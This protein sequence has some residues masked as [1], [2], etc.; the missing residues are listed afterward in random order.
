MT[1]FVGEARPEASDEAIV[2]R[3]VAAVMEHKL[4]PGAKLAENALCEAFG[5]NRTQIR[6][7]LVVLGERGVVTLHPN[8]GAFVWRPSAEEA[9]E[10]FSAR[11]VVET[12][13]VRGAAEGVGAEGVGR[14]RE[15]VAA[16]EAAVHRADEREAIRLSGQFHIAIAEIA[17]NMVLTR[18]LEDLVARTSLIIAFYGARTQACADCDHDEIIA[19][20][21]ARDAERA[22]VLMERHLQRIEDELDIRES[23]ERPLDIRELFS[24]PSAALAD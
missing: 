9:R 5:V 22:G 21:N 3:I 4:P 24:A 6:R 13:I 19:A 12:A 8:R 14:L 10:V 15:I 17:G 20:L 1:S 18:F 7:I 11:R 16:G 2:E 23:V